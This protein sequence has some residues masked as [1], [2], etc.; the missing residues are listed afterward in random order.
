M[1][2]RD[3]LAS[4]PVPRD[5]ARMALEHLV[6]G[7]V[8][9]GVR[10]GYAIRRR[11]D[12][13]LGGRGTVQPSHV[14]GVLAALERGGLVTARA[15]EESG[16]RR[17]SFDPTPAGAARLAAWLASSPPDV[18]AVLR[19]ALLVKLSV[20]ALLEAPPSR[21]EI[22]AERAARREGRRPMLAPE[23]VLAR[24]LRDRTERRREV[25]LRLLERVAS[26]GGPRDA[27]T[28]SRPG[29]GSR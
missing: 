10:H 14:Y 4:W 1:I 25:L 12:D 26:C 16:R 15:R 7:L 19:D 24:V 23:D 13:A 3:A 22:A 29:S 21:R 20:R 11:I 17:R 5:A 28:R 27:T 6:L 18:A 8:A 2:A 9:G